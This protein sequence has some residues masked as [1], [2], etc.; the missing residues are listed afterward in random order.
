MKNEKRKT[1]NEKATAEKGRA[2]YFLAFFFLISSFLFFTGCQDPFIA[3]NAANIP[4]GKGSFSLTLSEGRTVLP[5]TPSLSA[6]AVYNLAFT[7]VSGGS[8]VTVDR[9]NA[10]LSTQQIL[11]EPGTYN[12][13]VNAYNDIGKSQLMARGSS[14]GIVI[15]AG[16]N[17]AKVVTLEALLTGGTGAF[18]WNITV[19]SGVTNASMI[20]APANVGGTALQTV[21]LSVNNNTGSRTL[22]SGQYNLTINLESPSGRVVWK[23]LLYVYQN[24]SSNFTFEFTNAHFGG[25][26]TVTYNSNGGS[27][28]GQQSVLYGSTVSAPVAPTKDGYYFVGWYKEPA[29]TNV[30]NFATDTVTHDIILYAYWVDVAYLWYINNPNATT[31]NISTAAELVAFAK[32]V[33]GTEDGIAQF[34]FNGRTVNLT[35]NISLNNEPWT[36]IGN[37][38]SYGSDNNRPFRGIFDGN[39]KT[40]T[41]LY[42]NAPTADRQG[43]FGYIYGGSGNNGIIRNIAISGNITGNSYVGG[44]AGDT[45]Y[46]SI[47]DCSFNGTVTGNDSHVG[48]VVGYSDSSAIIRCYFKGSVTGGIDVG[49]VVGSNYGSSVR[50]SYAMGSVTGNGTGIVNNTG[51]GGVVGWNSAGSTV[52]D[53]YSTSN[54][55]FVGS[56]SVIGA[57]GIGGVVGAQQG[58]SN[59]GGTPAYVYNC[60]ATGTVGDSGGYVG[61]IIGK[62]VANSIVRNCVALNS[63][64]IVGSSSTSTTSNNYRLGTTVSSQDA[65]SLAW[66]M[67]EDN[68]YTA[69][70]PNTVNTWDFTSVWVWDNITNRPKLRDVGGQ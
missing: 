42:I 47:R 56:S 66:W 2:V 8:A 68:W 18:S 44:V 41:G 50:R 25:F 14:Y 46:A 65:S 20:I 31:F 1:K 37:Y 52:E 48:G 69:P 53:C 16:Q 35:A 19:P 23:E 39:S 6:F 43:F 58:A 7:P 3:H 51:I 34:D 33:N 36:P 55:V 54:V 11:L 60:Y 15:T 63:L 4:D 5:E 21:T 49:G 27:N 59:T 45:D 29:F 62:N 17:T 13:T 57:V 70:W 26:Y 28:V 24:L 40:I 10:N 67:N 64:S 32:I 9:T 30:W 38:I 22:N 12:L 61:G